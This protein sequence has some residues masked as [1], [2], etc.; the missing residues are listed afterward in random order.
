MI[1]SPE[2]PLHRL[3][4]S[5]SDALDMVHPKIVDHQL[6]VAYITTRIARAMGY[7]GE[8]LWDVFQAAA[9]HDI[10]LIGIENRLRALHHG[11]L[12]KVSW[13]PRVGYELLRDN[14]LFRRAGDI[15]RHHHVAWAGGKGDE[16]EGQRVPMASHIL[17]LADALERG[18]DRRL[19]IVEQSDFILSQATLGAGK[20]FHPQCVDALRSVARTEAFWLDLDSKH[21]YGVLLREVTWPTLTLDQG[22][23][24]PVA[25][26]FAR[27][28]DS[29]SRWTAVH[30]AGVAATSVALASR[31]HFA[32]RGLRAMRAAA[33]FHDLGKLTVPSAILDKPGKLNREEFSIIRGHT[34]HTFRLL[35][36]IGGLEEINEWAAFHHERLDGTG[37]PFHHGGEQL[38]LGSRI[39]GVADTF[40][41]VTEDRPYRKG[42]ER[43]QCMGVIEKMSA[44]GALDGDV[45]SVLKRDYEEIDAI[46]CAE[47]QAYAEKQ[48][49]LAWFMFPPKRKRLGRLQRSD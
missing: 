22:A 6:R 37:Y 8:E 14:P 20:R 18:I 44:E 41:A 24:G 23:L 16:N 28:V 31:L 29:A 45:V 19:P 7:Q 15:L 4:L 47:Q 12:E 39:M 1:V 21:L 48:Q 27:V 30:A 32:P 13:H 9:L 25:E 2:V 17:V 42:M 35:E 10:G 26:I 40:T 5:L 3:V 34:Y 49:R 33:Y 36:T 38:T 43:G 11:Q 46:R